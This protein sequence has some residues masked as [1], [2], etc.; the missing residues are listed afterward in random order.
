MHISALY[1]RTERVGVRKSARD[2]NAQRAP[3]E[4]EGLFAPAEFGA[5]MANLL[6]GIWLRVLPR[7]Q[8]IGRTQRRLHDAARHAENMAGSRSNAKRSVEVAFFEKSNVQEPRFNL[9]RQLAHCQNR[10][11]VE[12]GSCGVHARICTFRLLGDTRHV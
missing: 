3:R 7:N 2:G 1:G 11:N 10:V 9:P 4:V 5:F 12:A 8:V 6:K